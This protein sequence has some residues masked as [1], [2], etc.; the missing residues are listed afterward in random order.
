VLLSAAIAA[1]DT[2]VPA[3]AAGELPWQERYDLDVQAWCDNVIEFAATLD[4]APSSRGWAYLFEEHG[5]EKSDFDSAQRLINDCRKRGWL[6]LDICSVDERRSAD[7]LEELDDPDPETRAA[8]I[9][10]YVKRSHRSYDPCSFWD[11]QDVYLQIAVEKIDLKNLFAPICE[12]LHIPLVN[13]SGWTDLHSRA[14]MMERFR[15]R[16]ME[17]KEIVLLF[18]GDYDP[19]GLQISKFIRDNLED[20]A[21]AVDWSPDI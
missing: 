10:E 5:L 16:E 2:A 7:Y 4:F 12:P 3:P 1:A 17:D 20:L 13:F 15:D 11:D 6:P 8:E 14:D 19:G 9:M 21:N 18:C